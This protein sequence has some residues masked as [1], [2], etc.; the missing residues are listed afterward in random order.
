MGVEGVKK[1]RGGRVVVLVVVRVHTKDTVVPGNETMR[2]ANVKGHRNAAT[3]PNTCAHKRQQW[4]LT[5]APD[6][7]G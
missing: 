5:V 7:E 4:C 3:M 1:G 2:R 6:E